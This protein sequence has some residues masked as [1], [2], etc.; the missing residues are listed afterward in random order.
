MIH[1]LL[2]LVLPPLGAM[3][4]EA[5]P[6][7]EVVSADHPVVKQVIS[8]TERTRTIQASFVQEKFVS[9]LQEPIVSPGSLSW[10]APDRVR[11]EV[12]G[13]RPTTILSVGTQVRVT[14]DGEEKQLGPGEKRIYGTI[15]E[16]MKGLMSGSSLTDPGMA[17]KY[18]L[19][20][21]HLLVSLT[22]QEELLSRRVENIALKFDRSSGKL[23]RMSMQQKDGDR[24]VLT[25]SSVVLDARLPAGTFTDL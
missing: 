18:V 5:Y 12:K 7:G 2:F 11:W 4:P 14:Q 1:L 9:M 20:P 25:F 8:L 19:E 24:T 3:L 17:P 15:N 22:P 6:E 10:S 21:D 16:I 23:L 13:E